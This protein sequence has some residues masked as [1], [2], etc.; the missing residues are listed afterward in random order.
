MRGWHSNVTA[1]FTLGR[2][3][4]WKAAA[5][6]RR[7]SLPSPLRRP[8]SFPT[9]TA[10]A[11]TVAK[12]SR[13]PGSSPLDFSGYFSSEPRFRLLGRGWLFAVVLHNRGPAQ[14]FNISRHF[15]SVY[16]GT[17]MFELSKR[18]DVSL[19]V[20]MLELLAMKDSARD[21]ESLH[22][23][24]RLQSARSAWQ[25]IAVADN[26]P[27]TSAAIKNPTPRIVHDA[28][29]HERLPPG[30]QS[31]RAFAYFVLGLGRFA[32][33]S[34]ARLLVVKL[35]LSMSAT[36]DVL[37]L[38]SLEVDLSKM[39]P[40]STV[41]IKWRG[42]PVF[43]RQR[44]EEEIDWA[45]HEDWTS[46]WDPQPDS[47]R[48]QDPEWLVVVGVCMHLGCIPL[49][50][51]GNYGS[52]FCPCHGSHYDISG[53]ARKVPAPLNLEVPVY[54]FLDERRLLIGSQ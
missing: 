12:S 18:G 6:G 51:A 38:A 20:F 9:A 42:K 41:T 34:V 31:K 24:F 10:A 16:L 45:N 11:A 36:R 2:A 23:M 48:V 8:S 49:P 30:S 3:S 54:T 25:R 1:K 53:R 7:L 26:V 39:D 5:A 4:T 47:V 17:F 15:M 29:K 40:G 22:V 46:L 33:V 35:V 44:T 50:N 27:P 14:D 28:Y 43:I 19:C 52:W 21:H 37:A 13:D 32:S